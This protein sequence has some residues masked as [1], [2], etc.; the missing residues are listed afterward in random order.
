MCL[1]IPCRRLTRKAAGGPLSGKTHVFPL[2]GAV[3]AAFLV[4]A[5]AFAHS[6]VYQRTIGVRTERPLT[7]TLDVR[8][9]R[10][11]VLPGRT[12]DSVRIDVRR[13]DD[14]RP[15]SVRYSKESSRLRIRFRSGSWS[16]SGSSSN[17]PDVTIEL[18]TGVE[19]VVRM[20]LGAGELFV[21][22]GGLAVREAELSIW[23]GEAEVVC[24]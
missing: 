18:P 3:L 14:E 7:L 8:A 22:L 1:A 16:R 11:T 6:D 24:R 9:G 17:T 12:P 2:G 20:K 19:M 15:P 23:A 13:F 4:A 5:P 21:E 10:L